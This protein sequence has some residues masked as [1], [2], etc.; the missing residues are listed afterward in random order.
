MSRRVAAGMRSGVGPGAEPDA[1]AGVRPGVDPDADPDGRPGPDSGAGGGADPGEDTDADPGG[2]G[3][4]AMAPMLRCRAMKG[5]VRR[6]ALA[7]A[8]LVVAVLIAFGGAGIVTG[9][10]HEPGTPS[11]AELTYAGDAAIEPALAAIQEELTGL[12]ADVRRLSDL[13]RGALTALVATDIET[14]DA[15]VGEGEE[16]SLA[17]QVRINNLR[18]RLEALPG[19]GA[20]AELALSSDVRHRLSVIG[21]ALDSAAG[22]PPAWTRVATGSLAATSVTTML[23]DHDRKTA[24]AAADGRAGRYDDALAKLDESDKLIADARR[25]RDT[26]ANTVDVSTLTTWLDLNADYDRALRSLYEAIVESNGK[27]TDKVRAA[28]TAEAEAR[29]RLPGDTRPLIIILLDIARGGL[30]GAVIGIE[31]ARADIDAAI[32]ELEPA[33]SGSPAP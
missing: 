25:L 13:G 11:R 8:W 30:N 24:D 31:E 15:R 23:T 5:Q 2:R 19:N 29:D 21:T 6:V 3:A 9:M 1:G 20:G 16:L 26:L 22:L 12:A 4:S 10:A 7:V 32:G 27:V 17:I 28:F 33:A 18:A 14:L